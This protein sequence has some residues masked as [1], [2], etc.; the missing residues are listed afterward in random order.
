MLNLFTFIVDGFNSIF[1]GFAAVGNWIPISVFSVTSLFFIFLPKAS[2]HVD[3]SVQ[4]SST[5]SVSTMIQTSGTDSVSTA[6]QTDPV[7]VVN[8]SKDFMDTISPASPLSP[9]ITP[10]S[11]R[12]VLEV[13]EYEVAVQTDGIILVAQ[14]VQVDSLLY[15]WM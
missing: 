11:P 15:R 4:T 6:V 7:L 2:T 8:L 10:T 9:T 3:Q 12:L 1:L 13:V 5:E 14:G